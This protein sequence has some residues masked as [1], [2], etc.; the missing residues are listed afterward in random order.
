M[1]QKQRKVRSFSCFIGLSPMLICQSY[2]KIPIVQVFY[3]K[4]ET[5]PLTRG[6]LILTT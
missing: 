6:R 3:K 5:S 1:L 2:D 4:N